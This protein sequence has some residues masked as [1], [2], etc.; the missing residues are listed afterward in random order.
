MWRLHKMSIAQDVMKKNEEVLGGI[1][2]EEVDM[3]C[4]I[5]H[6]GRKKGID[7]FLGLWCCF[8]WIYFQLF[9]V[10]IFYFPVCPKPRTIDQENILLP[11]KLIYIL[12]YI[13]FFKYNRQVHRT[14]LYCRA[15]W[16]LKW[17][18]C[19]GKMMGSA[20]QCHST[21]A[22]VAAILARR[23]YLFCCRPMFIYF[24]HIYMSRYT[25]TSTSCS[26]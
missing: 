19:L 14:P 16:P 13:L 3:A 7:I 6:Y 11:S 12:L 23:V 20:R 8:V 9:R 22:A 15:T 18:L 4:I 5:H 17:I 2:K 25:C 24:D 26:F 1:E 10:P 21:F